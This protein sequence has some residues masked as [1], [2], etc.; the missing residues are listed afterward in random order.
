LFLVTGL[1]GGFVAV[2]TKGRPIPEA[3]AQLLGAS[4]TGS[5]ALAYAQVAV[6]WEL[7][8]WLTLGLSGLAGTTIARVQIRFA[9]SDAGDW[10]I[11]VVGATMFGQ[12]TWR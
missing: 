7:S 11:P 1:G 6:G 10:G 3:G 8:N 4:S 9:G 2:V 5:T 12:V